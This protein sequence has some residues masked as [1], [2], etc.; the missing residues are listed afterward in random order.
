[1]AGRYLICTDLDRTLIPNGPH[2]ESPVA[3]GYFKAL[4]YRRDI[5][6]TYVSGRHRAL[7]EQ[8]ID[9]YRLPIPDFVVGDVGTTI[10]QL[11]PDSKWLLS[12]SWRSN[13][14]ADWSGHT[15]HEILE[16]LAPVA[17]LRTQEAEKLNRFKLSYYFDTEES[18]ELLG[19]HI[20]EAMAQMDVAARLVWSMDDLTG[21]GLLDV[22]PKRA[23]KRHAIEFL[24][25][26]QG[27]SLDRTVFCG[28]S[29]NDLEVLVSPIPSVL[30]A[31]A[32]DDIKQTAVSESR[33]QK[34]ANELY[35]AR[36]GLL[37][38]NGNY[39]GGVLEG[40]IHFHP[41]L[42]GYLPAAAEKRV[43]K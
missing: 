43:R 1:M 21:E 27:F 26:E 29:G 5:V 11:D 31:N 41:E 16:A 38:M 8:A 36:G 19:A 9:Q 33:K 24:M 23:S 32:R 25:R 15:A 6:L 30:V 10:Y 40:I 20:M 13:I 35:I 28:D 14:A 37:G 18:R 22:L 34:T 2:L 3:A 17:A 7:V 42:K 39:R 12:Q 4:A